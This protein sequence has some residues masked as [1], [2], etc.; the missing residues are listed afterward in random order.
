MAKSQYLSNKL[1]SEVLTN[2]GYTGPTTVYAALFSVDPQQGGIEFSGG[3][4]ARQVVTFSA[5]VSGS[6]TNTNTPSFVSLPAGSANYV[7]LYDA[8]SGGNLLYSQLVSNPK[9]VPAGG[10]ILFAIGSIVVKES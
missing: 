5:P 3:S 9:T 2:V 1:L 7:G 4:Y 10:S 6:T 8:I